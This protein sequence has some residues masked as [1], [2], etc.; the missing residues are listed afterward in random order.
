M[1]NPVFRIQDGKTYEKEIAKEKWPNDQFFLN[2]DKKE[3]IRKFLKKYSDLHKSDEI[4]MLKTGKKALEGAI[5]EGNVT[6]ISKFIDQDIRLLRENFGQAQENIL[7]FTI[8]KRA[9]FLKTYF[10][11]SIAHVK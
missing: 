9:V 6:N 2:Q 8:K 3:A 11:L 5:C 4:Y 10:L 7:L 1:L